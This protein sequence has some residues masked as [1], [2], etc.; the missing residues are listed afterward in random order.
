MLRIW[1]WPDSDP[2]SGP[3]HQQSWII[4]WFSP[5]SR[6]ESWGWRAI[7]VRQPPHLCPI[8]AARSA[9]PQGCPAGQSAT[10][11][12]PRM[13]STDPHPH[14]YLVSGPHWCQRHA[15]SPQPRGAGRRYHWG[16][17]PHPHLPPVR[18]LQVDHA[19]P[20]GHFSPPPPLR[21]QSTS[22]ARLLPL[23]EC[24]ET[25]CQNRGWVC[26]EFSTGQP[27]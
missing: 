7:Y 6:E 15:A 1:S 4:T 19:A 2:D 21:S 17:A 23:V 10:P 16:H 3:L 5:F 8:Y 14:I 22:C 24:C 13:T 12:P 11:R 20:A 25:A 9:A 27:D 26:M 18:M